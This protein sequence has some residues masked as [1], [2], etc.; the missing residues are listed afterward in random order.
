MHLVCSGAGETE[1]SGQEATQRVDRRA[2]LVEQVL[3]DEGGRRRGK[4]AKFR[5]GAELG[6]KACYIFKQAALPASAHFVDI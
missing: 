5:S 3:R 2:G 6:N 1:C 4:G